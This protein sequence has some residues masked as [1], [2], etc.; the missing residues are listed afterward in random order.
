MIF[1]IWH[2]VRFF[3]GGLAVLYAVWFTA[4]VLLKPA[5][6]ILPHPVDVW[7]TLVA[8][9]GEL[10]RHTWVTTQE[11]GLGFILGLLGAFLL[12]CLSVRSD[13][14]DAMIS[15]LAV[16]MQSVPKIALAPLFI[17]W[18]GYG[19][20]PKIVIAAL[21]SFFPLFINL[22]GGMK[23]VDSEYLDY[24][25]TLRMRPWSVI[26]RIRL[27]FAMPFFF[28]ALKMAVIYSVVGAIV[29]EFVGADRG[30]GYLI[31]Q[32]DLSFNSALLFA[33]IH[34]LVLIGITLY[35]GVALLEG[36]VL[37]WKTGNQ[38]GLGIL[39]TA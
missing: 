6:Y 26:L 11:F 34:V 39:A 15:P 38:M 17:I 25:A 22:T 32:A 28:A 23:S 16:I 4:I 14:L 7:R 13:R 18:F 12:S 36:W 29:G 30:L 21:I 5:P 10:L 27:P 2:F 8:V 24:A 37:R 9:R 1:R 31:I 19:M 33:A 20:G 35:G 3:L